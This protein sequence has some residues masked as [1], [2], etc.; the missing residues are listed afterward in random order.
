[1]NFS[2]H[3]ILI[4]L[5]FKIE[6]ASVENNLGFIQISHDSLLAYV[7]DHKD[8]NKIPQSHKVR[9]NLQESLKIIFRII[10]KLD[11][12]WLNYDKISMWSSRFYW[13]R[14]KTSEEAIWIIA[15]KMEQTSFNV[16]VRNLRRSPE[17]VDKNKKFN[18]STNSIHH[19]K[20]INI[21]HSVSIIRM[22]VDSIMLHQKF[23]E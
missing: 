7:D 3:L 6:S 21:K 8:L 1:M 19:K 23:V 13:L 14:S 16:E 12:K 10:Q 22:M 9:K 2:F 4:S 20:F 18:L 17:C 15:N 11:G 5:I